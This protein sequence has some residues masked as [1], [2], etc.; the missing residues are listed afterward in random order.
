MSEETPPEAIFD[1][2][3]VFAVDDYMYFYG[4]WLTDERSSAEV[5]GLVKLLA[6]DAPMRVLDLACG[7]G[8]H[9][10][11]LAALGHSVVG[12][13]Y[14]P[15]FLEIARADAQ[16]MGV[17]VDYRQGDM[18]TLDLQDEFDR[19]LILF[20]TFGYFSDEENAAVLANAARALKPGGLLGF[21]LPNRDMTL[22]TLV[23]ASVEEK[24]G[25]LMI[26]R[27]SF[28]PLTGRWINRRIVIRDGVRRDKPFF[29]RL[30]NYSEIRQLLEAAGLEVQTVCANWRE[31]PF[32]PESRGMVIVARKAGVDRE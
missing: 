24:E 19:V 22:K 21:D 12:I 7:F 6:L 25:N 18:R 32:T 23:P 2:E 20:T 17:D 13:D 29:I 4:D 1:L 26:N 16:R 5:D 8:R 15:G 27:S 28:D 30:Y 9:A 31:E 10:N 14:T 11:R 3:A